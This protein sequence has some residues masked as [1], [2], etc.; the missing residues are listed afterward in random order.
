MTNQIDEFIGLRVLELR[1]EKSIDIEAASLACGV[2][3]DRFEACEAGRHTFT[4][5][6]L[7]QLTQFLDVQVAEFFAGLHG[8]ARDNSNSRR[9]NG[10]MDPAAAH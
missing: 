5:G 6:E 3:Q 7:F 4:A 2:S 9:S 10:L 8:V 1:I